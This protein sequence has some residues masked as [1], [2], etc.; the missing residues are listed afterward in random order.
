MGNE[1]AKGRYLR[2]K[3]ANFG[4]GLKDQSSGK[5]LPLFVDILKVHKNGV[6]LFLR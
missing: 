3:Y 4:C 2:P 5:Q 1:G 6:F